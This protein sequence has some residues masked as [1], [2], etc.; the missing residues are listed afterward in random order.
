[1]EEQGERLPVVRR[2]DLHGKMKGWI[3][4]I[5]QVEPSATQGTRAWLNLL[6]QYGLAPVKPWGSKEEARHGVSQ[7]ASQRDGQLKRPSKGE[8][9]EKGASTCQAA[10]KR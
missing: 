7:A 9:A 1:M 5:L 2:V 10:K 4:R 3:G 6:Q 8:T